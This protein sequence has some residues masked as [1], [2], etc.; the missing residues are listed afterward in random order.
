MKIIAVGMNY[1]RHNEELG[2][3]LVN[4]D[5]VIFMKPDYAILKDGKPLF[6]PC[7]L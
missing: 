3:V 5:P 2:N 4:K 6:I 1:A 7:I